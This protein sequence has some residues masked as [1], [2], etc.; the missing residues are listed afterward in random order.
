VFDRDGR[1]VGHM[2]FGSAHDVPPRNL[3]R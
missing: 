1:L 3:R 2:P